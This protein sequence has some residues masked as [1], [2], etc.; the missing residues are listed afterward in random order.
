MVLTNETKQS[1]KQALSCELSYL[2]LGV[3]FLAI[4]FLTHFPFLQNSSP[5]ALCYKSLNLLFLWMA[6]KE[7]SKPDS[8]LCY[9]S[10]NPK[11]AMKVKAIPS[12]QLH[13]S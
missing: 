1:E 12:K 7:C 4:I 10:A 5:D 3:L 8:T 13:C 11:Q 2:G 9:Y 6:R